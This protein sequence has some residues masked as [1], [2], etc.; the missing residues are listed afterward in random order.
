MYLF[1]SLIVLRIRINNRQ[2]IMPLRGTKRPPPHPG[3]SNG[4]SCGPAGGSGRFSAPYTRPLRTNPPVH[5]H[6]GQAECIRLAVLAGKKRKDERGGPSFHHSS[7]RIHHF[8]LA[9]AF[10]QNIRAVL[11]QNHAMSYQRPAAGM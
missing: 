9:S 7:F 11:S 8:D 4:S 2:L 6:H 1:R 10:S 5:Y 3:N